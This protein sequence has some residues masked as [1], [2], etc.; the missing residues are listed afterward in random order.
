MTTQKTVKP[1][2]REWGGWLGLL[3]LLGGLWFLISPWVLG[4]GPTGAAGTNAIIVGVLIAVCG[5]LDAFGFGHLTV[6]AMRV[7][8][9]LAALLG[10]WA[11]LSPFVLNFDG[12]ARWDAIVTGLFVFLVSSYETW[13]LPSFAQASHA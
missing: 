8:G 2:T 4:F 1:F 9:V 10:L 7:F 12:I 6:R 11:I 5:A 13:K 3:A